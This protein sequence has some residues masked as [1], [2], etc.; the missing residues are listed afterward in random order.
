[1]KFSAFLIQCICDLCTKN[2]CCILKFQENTGIFDQ[3]RNF[4][5]LQIDVILYFAMKGEIY[6]CTFKEGDFIFSSALDEN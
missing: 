6:L 5:C 3:A 2:G 1:M 4:E